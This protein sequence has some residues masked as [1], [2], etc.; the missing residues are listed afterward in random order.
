MTLIYERKSCYEKIIATLLV[1]VGASAMVF[2]TTTDCK[3]VTTQTETVTTDATVD[4]TKEDVTTE[5]TTTK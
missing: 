2:A 4:V 1:L 5:K 3:T